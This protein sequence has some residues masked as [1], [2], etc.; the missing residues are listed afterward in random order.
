MLNEGSNVLIGYS[1]RLLQDKQ[2]TRNSIQ[3]SQNRQGEDERLNPTLTP[4]S[5]PTCPL[6]IFYLRILFPLTH[7]EYVFSN[8]GVHMNSKRRR[9]ARAERVRISILTK[10]YVIVQ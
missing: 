5:L 8:H 1:I 9:T 4:S 6:L 3:A 7:A 10:F 2:V